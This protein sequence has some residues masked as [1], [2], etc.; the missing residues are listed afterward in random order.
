MACHPSSF[1]ALDDFAVRVI[2][3]EAEKLGRRHGLET[4]RVCRILMRTAT[5]ANGRPLAAAVAG[6][7]NLSDGLLFRPSLDDAL[8]YLP[9][10]DAL[11]LFERE[12]LRRSDDRESVTSYLDYHLAFF[13]KP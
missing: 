12:D 11:A 4:E 10:E 7:D 1:T 9:P 6:Q 5:D 8:R 2:R 13:T 3:H